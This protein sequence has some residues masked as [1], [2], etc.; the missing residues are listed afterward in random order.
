MGTPE[1]SIVIPTFN[2][3]GPL[4]GCL[5]AIA[6][7][8]MDRD[9]FEV[10]VVD[11]HSPDSQ[12]AVAD[13]FAGQVNL[14]FFR[15]PVNQG[16]AAARNRGAELATGKYV[17]FTDDDCMPHEDWLTVFQRH[18]ENGDEVMLGGHTINVLGD[19]AF[20]QASQVLV[21]YL[22]ENLTTASGVPTF[23]TSNNIC[24]PRQLFFETGGF[25]TGFPRAAAEDR[26]FGHRFR[27]MGYD[28]VYTPAAL[29]KHAHEL[30]F[31]SYLR[32]HFFY[33]AGALQFRKLMQQNELQPPRIEPLKF[34][35][36]MMTHPFSR[37][38]WA[39]ATVCAGLLL[40][41]QL[42]NTAGFFWQVARKS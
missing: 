12:R 7:L 24:L 17:C 39:S 4:R 19:N 32:Q 16:P 33:G 26:E 20:S 1:F 42:A 21:D 22:Y 3:P 9:A 2:R 15:Q 40:V 11:D 30:G 34:Y 37:M 18:L 23:F 36:G 5:E 29:V 14:V 13:E 6:G 31:R 35:T 10:I 25:D 28:L 41:S 38:G 8:A 27:A